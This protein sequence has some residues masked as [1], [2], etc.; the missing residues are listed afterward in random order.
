MRVTL[1]M[2]A[3]KG[4]VVEFSYQFCR[5][6]YRTLK[7]MNFIVQASTDRGNTKEKNQDSLS[8]KVVNTSIGKMVFAVL[9]DGMGGLEKG[10]VASATIV[11]AYNKWLINELPLLCNTG[12]S[13][14]DIRRAWVGIADEYNEKIKSYGKSHGVSLG[15]TLTAMLITSNRYYIINI[16]DT[17]AYEIDK[18]VIIL[19][20]DQTLVAREIDHGRL[21]K[22]EAAVDSRRN[23]LLQCIGASDHIYPDMFFGVTKKDTVYMLCSDGFRHE[24]SQEEIYAYMQP[25]QMSDPNRMKAN[26]D[27]L[28]QLNKDR[29]ERDNISVIAVRTY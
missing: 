25:S 16:G 19:T 4:G 14:G 5:T 26:M 9:C 10:E 2:H 29:L 12:I 7:S 24:I 17:R 20:R 6:S 23:V 27:M 15:T 13:D 3:K 28:I 8:V 22:E 21:T 18:E 11:N 1:Y